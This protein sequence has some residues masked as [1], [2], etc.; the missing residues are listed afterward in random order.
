MDTSLKRAPGVG[1]CLSLHFSLYT[2]NTLL[3]QTLNSLYSSTRLVEHLS[4]V[5]FYWDQPFLV[6]RAF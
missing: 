5:V 3:Q 4:K 6:G 1:P 2:T